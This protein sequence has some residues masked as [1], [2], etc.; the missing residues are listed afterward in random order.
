MTRWIGIH[1]C[2]NSGIGSWIALLVLKD[3]LI[4]DNYGSINDDDIDDNNADAVM[5]EFESTLI[6]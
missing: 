2:Y 1:T 4:T 3:Q 5:N 6:Q